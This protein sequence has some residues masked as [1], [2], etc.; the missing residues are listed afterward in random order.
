[1]IAAKI[2]GSGASVSDVYVAANVYINVY[3]ENSAVNFGGVAGTAENTLISAAFAAVNVFLQTK[4]PE[5]S[6]ASSER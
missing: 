6:A 5:I 2:G 3:I 1:M 4:F